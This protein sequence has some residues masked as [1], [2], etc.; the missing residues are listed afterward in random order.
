MATR[1]QFTM[2]AAERRRRLKYQVIAFLFI[3]MNAKGNFWL[4][5]LKTG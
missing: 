1:T 3:K 5:I 2:T 4:F